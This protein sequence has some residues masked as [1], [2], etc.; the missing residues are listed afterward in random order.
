MT[1]TNTTATMRLDLCA[2][3][4]CGPLAVFP[5]VG[6]KGRLHYRSLSRAVRRGA[7]IAEV[8]GE[9]SVR[10]VLVCNASDAPVLLYEGELIEGAR[11]HR[12]FDQPVLVPAGVQLRVLVSC[13]EQGR[14][15]ASQHDGR[16]APSAHAADPQLRGA[17]RAEANRRA[18]VG[19]DARPEQ[20]AVWNGVAERLRRHKVRSLSGALTDVYRANRAQLDELRSAVAPLENQLGA[21][22]QVDGR[23]VAL[24]LV[25]RPRVFGELLPRLADGYALQ[26]LLATQ[27]EPRPGPSRTA[28]HAFLSSAVGSRRA[29]MPT[30][31]RGDAF[32]LTGADVAG[33]GLTADGA[34]ICLSAFPA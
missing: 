13:V 8:D 12:T 20:S 28:A 27:T 30:P 22:V 6:N 2:P 14:W 26:A 7:F 1:T 34:Q 9:G 31:G 15:D 18:A 32:R 3:Q 33:C 21:V 23:T 17:K 4:I 29:W 10:E 16:F 24:D 5:I 25:S 19:A 11:Q